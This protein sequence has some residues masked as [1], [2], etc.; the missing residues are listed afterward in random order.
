MEY[1][2]EFE[3]AG[4]SHGIEKRDDK[5]VL[6]A[7]GCVINDKMT[8]MVQARDMLKTYV[9]NHLEAMKG[10]HEDALKEIRS[11]LQQLY[12]HPAGIL[13]FLTAYKETDDAD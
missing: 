12:M 8:T 2:E 10:G 9:I 4:R 13:H 5:Y 3:V 7:G 11:E 1:D 6:W